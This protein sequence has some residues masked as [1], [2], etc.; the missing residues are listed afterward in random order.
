M[1]FLKTQ[2]FNPLRAKILCNQEGK[3]RGIGFVQ[4]VSQGEA[5]C[6]VQDL[7]SGVMG[8]RKLVVD[9]ACRPSV[10]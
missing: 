8:G 3:S 10:C 4:M 2:N 1:Y 9:M 7:Q 6:A 5:R